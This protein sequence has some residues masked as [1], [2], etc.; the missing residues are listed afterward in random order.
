MI[1]VKKQTA[2]TTVIYLGLIGLA[3]LCWSYKNKGNALQTK[4]I[5]KYNGI[6]KKSF[7]LFFERI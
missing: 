6:D 7:P 1:W 2:L 3:R 4:E 5:E